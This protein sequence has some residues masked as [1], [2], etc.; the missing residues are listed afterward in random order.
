MGVVVNGTPDCPPL[1]IDTLHI[2]L[3]QEGRFDAVWVKPKVGEVAL[4]SST[5]KPKYRIGESVSVSE[6]N[7]TMTQLQQKPLS[8]QANSTF[9]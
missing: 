8:P 9:R 7:R 2:K 3:A 5:V 1:P 4:Y 6:L